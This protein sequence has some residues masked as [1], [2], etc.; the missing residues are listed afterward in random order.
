MKKISNLFL[1]KPIYFGFICFFVFFAM[2]VIPITYTYEKRNSF[3][4]ENFRH[5]LGM[6]AYAL[7]F[8]VDANLHR[9]IEDE[10]NSS[11]ESYQKATAPLF[12]FFSVYR[13]IYDIYTVIKK[14]DK[15]YYV[16]D[17]ANAQNMISK[18]SVVAPAEIME[19]LVETENPDNWF[20]LVE[21]GQIYVNKNFETD[22]Y[23]TFLSA[24]APIYDENQTFVGAIGID[25]SIKKYEEMIKKS[26][27]IFILSIILAIAISVLASFVVI[28]LINYAKMFYYQLQKVSNFD[29]LTGVYNRFVFIDIIS[30]EI[31]RISRTKDNLYLVFLDIDN[32]K[33]INDKY[34]HSIGDDVIMYTAQKITSAIRKVDIVS[35][36]G[37][38]EFL[39]SISGSNDEFI[40]DV[41]DRI[42]HQKYDFVYAPNKNGQ[43][44]KL[45]INFSI[46]YTKYT[47]GD[48]FESMLERADRAL[49]ISKDFGKHRATFI[50]K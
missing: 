37:G 3:E 25:V 35:R 32:F 13:E 45:I 10:Q 12:D 33:T 22:N 47:E 46:G 5:N 41:I 50:E 44:E 27:N 1:N 40:K 39:V 20:E 36:Y 8:S 15:K 11:S 16:L 29:R 17:V 28:L 34:G 42:L 4:Y 23:G 18:N 2:I 21:S 7:S 14:D 24:I 31:D 48:T 19:E 43:E 26:K 9:I 49:Y 30:R 6:A 38:D